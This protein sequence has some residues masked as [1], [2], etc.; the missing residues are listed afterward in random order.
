MGGALSRLPTGTPAPRHSR[1]QLTREE[2]ILGMGRLL[3]EIM[4]KKEYSYCAVYHSLLSV[5]VMGM[6]GGTSI[7]INGILGLRL[8]ICTFPRAVK[9]LN[10]CMHT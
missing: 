10:P 9:Q 8:H 7:A 6:Y 3:G 5:S 1:H 2:Q 4:N